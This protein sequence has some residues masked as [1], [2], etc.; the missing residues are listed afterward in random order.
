MKQVRETTIGKRFIF[1][2]KG[3]MKSPNEFRVFHKFL[4]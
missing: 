3:G 2:K 4:N 1:M